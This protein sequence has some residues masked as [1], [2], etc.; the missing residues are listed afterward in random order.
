MENAKRNR[1]HD[2]FLKYVYTVPENVHSFFNIASKTNEN[3]AAMLS[4]VDLST[5]E[6]I[7]EAYNEVQE[8]GEADVAFKVK[9]NSGEDVF[10]GIL[11]EH[12]SWPD[13]TVFSQIYRYTFKVMVDKS[14]EMFAWMPTKTVIIYNGNKKWDPF[15]RFRKKPKAKFQEKLL[16]FECVFVNLAEVADEHCFEELNAVAAIATLTMKYAFDS[17]G[18]EKIL[19]RIVEMLKSFGGE[20]AVCLVEKIELYLGE[21][22][23]QDARE[24]LKMAV[25][26]IGQLYGFV[27][28]NDAIRAE[29]KEME[30]EKKAIQAEKESL[31]AEKESIQAEKE[32]ILAEKE[33]ILAEKASILAEKAS[34]EARIRELEAMLA[35]R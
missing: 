18:F 6:E 22:F 19:P 20:K 27:S 13:D 4:E 24:K 2:G 9:A 16:P 23:S 10:F 1:N 7:P 28:V 34:M 30:I 26:S 25:K 33:S 15:E 21:F 17:E 3:L 31:T 5:L 35:M 8:R 11:L 29:R 12:K 32:L 14:D